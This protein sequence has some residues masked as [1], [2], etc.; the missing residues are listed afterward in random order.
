MHC[1]IP[2]PD[3]P[4]R[5]DGTVCLYKDY[6]YIV[7]TNHDSNELLLLDMVTR[8]AL[9]H[10]PSNDK[11]FDVAT[12]PLG[13]VQ[14]GPL[15]VAYVTRRPHRRYKQGLTYE[16]VYINM[17]SLDNTIGFTFFSEAMRNTIIRKYPPFEN[18]R[19]S[20]LNTK[21]R[22]EFAINNDCAVVVDKVL[23]PN[24]V[25]VFFRDEFVGNSTID[26]FKKPIPF[27]ELQNPKKTW[28]LEQ[29]LECFAFRR[30]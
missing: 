13:Y 14:Y 20:V 4:A 25:G 5:L 15:Q 1:N 11:D 30:Y 17:L 29:Y 26:E 24:N 3:L 10:I 21:E 8:K 23:Q 7:K 19:R 28:I 27:V 9:M 2:I 6:P 12:P 22:G 16:S 18:I